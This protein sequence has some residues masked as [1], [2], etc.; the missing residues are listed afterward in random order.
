MLVLVLLNKGSVVRMTFYLGLIVVCA[1]ISGL[2][3]KSTNPLEAYNISPAQRVIDNICALGV[4]IGIIG[5]IY[6]LIF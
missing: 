3:G 2:F 6:H 5:V 4:W 1:V